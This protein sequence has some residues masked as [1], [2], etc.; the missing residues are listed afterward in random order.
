MPFS[1]N[2]FKNIDI[3]PTAL[4][5]I[6]EEYI[7]PIVTIFLT[8]QN[9]IN[10]HRLIKK[11]INKRNTE[12]YIRAMVRQDNYF[13]FNQLLIE[14][15]ERWLHL[16][17]Y[18]YRSCIYSNYLHFLDDYC[19]DNESNE[20]RNLILKLLEELGLSRNQHKKNTVRYIRWKI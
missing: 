17:K 10:N 12:N 7:P 5:Q 11:Y 8:K 2:L 18:Y 15:W 13:V 4:I 3:L 1:K 6:I 20:C 9:Y 14:N 16:K 19:I